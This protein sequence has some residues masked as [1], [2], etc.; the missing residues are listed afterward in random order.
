[1]FVSYR[2]DDAPTTDRLSASLRER[3]GRDR[4][5]LDIASIEVGADFSDVIGDWIARCDVLLA[6]I[7]PGWLDAKTTS[8]ERRLDDPEDSMRLEIEA[9]LQQNVRVIPVLIQGAELPPRSD[10]PASLT[11]LLR[12]NA[13]ELGRKH[14]VTDVDELIAALERIA[15]DIRLT[16]PRAPERELA[17]EQAL[18]EVEQLAAELNLSP[19][20]VAAT[21]G[22]RLHNAGRN[23]EARFLLEAAAD[24]GDAMAANTLGLI[25]EEQGDP[26]EA[27]RRFRE[28]ADKGDNQA[29]YN[30]GRML[31]DDGDYEQAET[32]LSQSTDPEAIRLL[33][34]IRADRTK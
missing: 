3:F 12:R 19:A 30:L 21:L 28:S 16:E 29:R 34:K 24:R 26:D 9:A 8:G 33:A 13:L 23:A 15:V 7:G 27:R 22:V 1:V 6:I 17:E 4:V 11:P 20:A 25:M 10:L 18:P 32:V 2:R 31:S 14:W 5:F